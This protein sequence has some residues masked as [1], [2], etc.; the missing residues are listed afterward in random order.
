MSLLRSFFAASTEKVEEGGFF[1]QPGG[2]G[3]LFRGV[4]AF[5][6]QGQFG[7]AQ[8]GEFFGVDAFGSGAGAK[9]G[10]IGRIGPMRGWTK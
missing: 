2:D 5:A 10:K 4:F 8:A 7:P 9:L 1:A 6:G 3:Q